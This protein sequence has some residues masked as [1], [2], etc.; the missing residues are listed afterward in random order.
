MV[1]S[2]WIPESKISHV[3][4]M[5]GSHFKHTQGENPYKKELEIIVEPHTGSLIENQDFEHP[6]KPKP[7]IHQR[8]TERARPLSGFHN[9]QHPKN[10]I[11]F[12]RTTNKVP[13]NKKLAANENTVDDLEKAFK[14]VFKE[15]E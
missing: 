15:K 10:I 12:N 11:Q 13:S 7:N 4:F 14:E 1:I 3:P 9:P 5:Y 2:S 8:I 6:N